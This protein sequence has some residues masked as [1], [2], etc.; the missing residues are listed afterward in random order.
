MTLLTMNPGI[1][2]RG[3]SGEF[4]REIHPKKIRWGV[5]GTPLGPLHMCQNPLPGSQ[6]FPLEWE[7]TKKTRK[8]NRFQTQIPSRNEI[9]QT[10]SQ[11]DFLQPPPPH[12]KNPP[13]TYILSPTKLDATIKILVYNFD[14]WGS[15]GPKQ[16]KNLTFLE[17]LPQLK[18][19]IF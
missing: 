18:S 19:T 16:A 14:F 11:S 1:P 17:I 4:H 9:F 10:A 3:K 8:T 12:S 6:S 2:N 15:Y 5:K 13:S 7:G